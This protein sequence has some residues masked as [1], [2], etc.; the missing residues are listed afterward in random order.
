MGTASQKT[1]APTQPFNLSSGISS[2]Y[3]PSLSGYV[4][5]PVTTGNPITQVGAIPNI[6]NLASI[7]ESGN[8]SSTF[9]QQVYAGPGNGYCTATSR[10][11]C[12]AMHS[13]QTISFN[14]SNVASVT[15]ATVSIDHLDD[16][17][18]VA[19]NG[20]TVFAGNPCS[21]RCRGGAYW[22]TRDNPGNWGWV[23]FEQSN[24]WGYIG[25]VDVTSYL[26]NGNNTFTVDWGGT[27]YGDITTTLTVAQ[28]TAC[29]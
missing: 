7:T 8:P 23:F 3:V 10:G 6:T 24:G 5:D 19:I 17:G 29:Q 25:T 26:V 9:Q 20:M 1:Q 28:R 18:V 27:F 2:S 15:Q 21:G 13:T 22:L 4:F 16:G 11:R 12:T 14:V